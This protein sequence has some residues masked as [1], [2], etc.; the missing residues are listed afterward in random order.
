MK[1]SIVSNP[2]ASVQDKKE[3][4]SYC[5][6]QVVTLICAPLKINYATLQNHSF[7]LSIFDSLSSIA[8]GELVNEDESVLK[9]A[10][11]WI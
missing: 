9:T 5:F 10:I 6:N 3:R 7:A 4:A 1:Q 11:S 8:A 2:G